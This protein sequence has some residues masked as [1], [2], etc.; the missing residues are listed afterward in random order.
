MPA[1]RD[2]LLVFLK[3]PE[4]GAAKTRLVPVLG[5]EAAA[6][7]YRLLAEASMSATRPRDRE[8]AR[9]LCYA[10]PGARERIRGWFP[11]E[12]IW[13]QPEGDLGRRMASAF[14]EGFRL[15]AERVA[16]VGTDIPWVS[17]DLVRRAFLG[18]ASADVV[19]GPAHDGGYYLVALPRP[20]PALFEGMEW[21]TPGVLAVTRERAS[22]LGLRVQC[23]EP[24]HDID[25]L[26][27]LRDTWERLEPLLGR[28]PD[29]R[30]AVAR[31]I[32]RS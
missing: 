21:S 22:A 15:R 20:Q 6:R 3:W 1:M 25:T 7:L 19:L 31:A 27:D 11:E 29:L 14:E 4:P 24:M 23:L 16:L 2:L 30:L 32:G 13:A 18:L 12:P 26:D 10:P 5:V 8:Y 9:L 28:D 17:R